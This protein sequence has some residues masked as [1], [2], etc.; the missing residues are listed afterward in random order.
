M[1]REAIVNQDDTV[2]VM[3]A[4]G[5]LG[6]EVYRRLLLEG[7]KVVGSA[8][9]S[10]LLRF[11][12]EHDRLRDFFKNPALRQCT[13]IINCIGVVKSR[14]QGENPKSVEEAFK[15]NAI[16]P[17]LLADFAYE[18]GM[19]VIQVA[20]DCVFSGETGGYSESQVHD[21]NDLYGLT[22]SLGEPNN[23]ST[24]ILRSSLVGPELNGKS[25][26]LFE[27]VRGLPVGAEIQGFKDHY[28]NGLGSTT[29]SRIIS[30]IVREK[31]FRFGTQHLVPKAA[32]SK[33]ELLELL[34]RKLGRA[35][36][37]IKPVMV[38]RL[39][40]TLATINETQN[41]NLFLA[42]GYGEPPSI[43]DMIGELVP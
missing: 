17:H 12:A 41:R 19:R 10:P 33:Y 32:V 23:D 27:W 2:L 37:Q 22:K 14:I 3:G 42:A 5:M 36:I 30:A 15:V 38:G 18:R 25:R 24:M 8:R 39:D 13:I 21:P 31:N 40:R 26:L 9:N 7:H 4:D 34:I 28:W 20:T 1:A 43:R 11:S 6:S 16:F 35:D 29:I